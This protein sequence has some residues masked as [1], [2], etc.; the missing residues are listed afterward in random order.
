VYFERARKEVRKNRE[1][2]NFWFGVSCPLISFL[3]D[4]HTH[5]LSLS[6]GRQG[7][8]NNTRRRDRY[9]LRTTCMELISYHRISHIALCS[10]MSCQQER[11][12]PSLVPCD[13]GNR[14]A[15]L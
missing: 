5:S 13:A 7:A 11:K 6:L 2:I 4:A 14:C 10:F 12:V 1:K 8:Q 15:H 3:P 9:G